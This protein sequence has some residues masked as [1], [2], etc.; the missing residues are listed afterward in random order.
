MSTPSQIMEWDFH[1]PAGEALLETVNRLTLVAEYRDEGAHSHCRRVRCYTEMIANRL[2]ISGI[3]AGIM[4]FSSPMH[5]IGM[6]GIPDSILRKPEKLTAE[7]YE[8]MKTH[9]TI[10]A[11]I[12]GNSDNPYLVSARKFAVSHHERWDGSGYPFGLIGEEIPI[13]GRIMYLVDKYDTLRS[14]RPYKPPFQHDASVLIITRGNYNT[15]PEHFD[16]QILEIFASFDSGFRDIFNS[17]PT[18]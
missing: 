11:R 17:N 12:L 4:A 8:L 16:P 6:V 1:G 7:E 3:D 9:T 13:E 18:P 2:G 10:G 5:D 15:K 14:R